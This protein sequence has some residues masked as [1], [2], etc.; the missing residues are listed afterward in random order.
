MS[1]RSR[2]NGGKRA[3]EADEVSRL[4]ERERWLLAVYRGMSERDRSYLLRVAEV[5]SSTSG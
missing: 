2:P 1:N 4:T 3:R 5:I